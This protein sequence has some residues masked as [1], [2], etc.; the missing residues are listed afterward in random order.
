M[1]LIKTTLR[2]IAFLLC[3]ASALHCSA[4][5][6]IKDTKV[7][8]N[9]KGA[10]LKD[11]LME[12]ERQTGFSFFYLDK[13]VNRETGIS[14]EFAN[15]SL[16]SVLTELAKRSGLVFRREN[17]QIVVKSSAMPAQKKIRKADDGVVQGRVIDGL[18]AEPLVGASVY[19]KDIFIGSAT[20]L[21][22]KFVLNN[23]PEGRQILVVSYLGYETYE[24]EIA[25]VSGT[26]ESYEIRLENNMTE[27]GGIVVKGSL[28]GQEKALNQQRTADNIKN[29]V[30]AD[31]MSRFPDLNV[32]EALQ[33]VP[34]VTIN[35]RRGEGSTVQIR[36]TP[37]SFTTININGEQIPSTESDGTRNESLDLIPADVLSSLEI[38]KA[39]TPDMDG[40]AVGGSINMRSPIARST[41]PSIKAEGGL[42]YNDMSRGVNGIG[43]F[44]YG[45]RYGATE[46]LDEGRFGVKI[47]GSYFGSDNTQDVAEGFYMDLDRNSVSDNATDLIGETVIEEY[48]YGDYISNRSR[49]GATANLDY[50]FSENSDIRFNFIYSRRNDEDIRRRVRYDMDVGQY[51]TLNLSRGARVRR[52]IALRNIFKENYTSN[53]D[54]KFD[55]N[56]MV[57]D[58]GLFY[59]TARREDETSFLAFRRRLIDLEVDTTN[60]DFPVFSEEGSNS[61]IYDPL[62]INRVDRYENN[63]STNEGQNFVAK[64]NLEIPV[65]FGDHSGSVKAGGKFRTIAN[66][67]NRD[68]NIFSYRA[69]PMGL[70][71]YSEPEIYANLLT[72]FEDSR[73]LNDN[74]RFGRG[75]DEDKVNEFIDETFALGLWRPEAGQTAISELGF[76][77][78]AD[79]TVYSGYVMSKI[80]LKKLMILG[81]LRYEATTVDYASFQVTVDEQ[82]VEE[83]ETFLITGDTSFDFLLPNLHFK[84]ALNDMSNARAAITYSY[85]RPNFE[86]VVPFENINI[87]SERI[88]RGNP[89]LLPSNTLNLDLMYERYLENVGIISGG[90]F[91]KR[92]NDFLF[93][94]TINI[95]SSN[96]RPFFDEYPETFVDE[97]GNAVNFQLD[98]TENGEVAE[99]YGAEINIQTPLDFLPGFLSGL[100]LY[101]NYTYTYSKALLQDDRGEVSF[102]L[103]ADHSGNL[104]LS[105]D[106][107]GFTGRVSLN[108]LGEATTSFGGEPIEDRFR[109]ERYQ[110]DISLNQRISK[111]FSAFAEMLN[112]T[113]QP[114]IIY[115][116]IRS[117]PTE[118]EYF[119]WWNR[120]GISYRL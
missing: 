66:S 42:G 21:N 69:D 90:I 17:N 57:L 6:S 96:F 87:E 33:R 68:A 49:I 39:L 31:L 37:P 89:D 56:N 113:N 105:Y 91:Y 109:E 2:A 93:D 51:T 36:G 38:V 4:Q 73:F 70:Y 107:G 62:L 63:T 28:E 59:S 108:Y 114:I 78:D 55:L 52:D 102:P 30:S 41:D 77:Y 88:D 95:D 84:Y 110:I 1:T 72:D 58:G 104:A 7:S 94:R 106:R 48:R 117:R 75:L 5:K 32:A 26:V 115:Q 27:L 29:I 76:F 45:R 120:F 53:L 8:I 44:S 97:E 47:G 14:M 81:G 15:T 67:K 99:L 92:I 80:Q 9:M 22:G 74:M 112:V 3:L 54:F 34:G 46:A 101:M 65:K 86:E 116:G 10:S 98:Q 60:P 79:E 100:G 20:D 85:T 119:G 71:R 25:V 82:S 19:L 40:D 64:A 103:Q 118:I 83:D 11:V 50:K 13:P 16:E 111:K 35:R 61:S 43:R 12:I 24:Q 18:T 23:I